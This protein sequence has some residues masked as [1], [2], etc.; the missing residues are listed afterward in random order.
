[1][2]SPFPPLSPVQSELTLFAQENSTAVADTLRRADAWLSAQQ[3]ID[4]L[5]SEPHDPA[6]KNS[7]SSRRL[8]RRCAEALGSEIISGQSGYKHIDNATPDEVRHF[9][10]WMKSQGGKMV[11]R[12]DAALAR[13]GL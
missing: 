11:A 6:C 8:I 4:R 7:E 5:F 12:A 9:A 10:N 1:M 13:K 3:I 2:T